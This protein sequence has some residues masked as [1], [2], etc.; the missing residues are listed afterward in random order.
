MIDY[1]LSTNTVVSS[2]IF[3]AFVCLSTENC[4]SF[5][6]WAVD[7][8]KQQ[9]WQHCTA[10]FYA[11]F[12]NK[13]MKLFRGLVD[14]KWQPL[15]CLCMCWVHLLWLQDPHIFDCYR[16][17]C[18][19]NVQDHIYRFCSRKIILQMCLQQWDETAKKFGVCFMGLIIL[20]QLPFFPSPVSVC[21]KLFSVSYASFNLLVH[22]LWMERPRWDDVQL[23]IS[24]NTFN[25][26]ECLRSSGINCVTKCD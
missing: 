20:N 19:I 16:F 9:V 4:R 11:V 5:D 8:T 2:S 25:K 10:M 26:F 6:F 13:W 18:R 15:C 3:D 17:C 21:G 24:H 7:W 1:F 14:N 23:Q 22:P 12:A